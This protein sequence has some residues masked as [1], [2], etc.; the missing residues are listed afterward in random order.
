MSSKRDVQ[1]I[2]RRRVRRSL[3][4]ALRNGTYFDKVSGNLCRM[5]YG[6]GISR[7]MI[8]ERIR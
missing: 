5:R 3:K 1:N 7:E 6:A 2:V 4:D 8:R